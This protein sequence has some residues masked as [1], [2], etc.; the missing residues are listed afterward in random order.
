VTRGKGKP[1]FQA[2]RGTRAGRNTTSKGGVGKKALRKRRTKPRATCEPPVTVGEARGEI[3]RK[4]HEKKGG[5][6]RWE[7]E[8][9]PKRGTA[10]NR[11]SF[12]SDQKGEKK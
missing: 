10:G 6:R 4:N 2:R 11:G 7:G 5:K 3:K 9:G 8:E 12:C 1:D